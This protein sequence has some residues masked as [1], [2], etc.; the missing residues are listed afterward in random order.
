MTSATLFANQQF[1]KQLLKYLY[2][3]TTLEKLQETLLTF[4]KRLLKHLL[5]L[6]KKVC[7]QTAAFDY[8][9]EG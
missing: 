3:V 9:K 8:Y 4:T 6:T 7:A 2:A 5:V 1:L